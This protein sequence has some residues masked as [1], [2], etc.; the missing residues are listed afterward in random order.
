VISLIEYLRD[1]ACGWS[2]LGY[3][4]VSEDAHCG[5]IVSNLGLVAFERQSNI[6]V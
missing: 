6:S 1:S 5:R 4:Q 2:L 3:P